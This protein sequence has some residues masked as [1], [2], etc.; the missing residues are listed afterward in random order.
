MRLKEKVAI[1]TGAGS[2][3]GK[4]I[5]LR[6]ASEGAKVCIADLK[7]D[8]AQTTVDEIRRNGGEGLAVAMNVINEQQVDAG[9]AATVEKFGG[10]DILVSNAGIQHIDA[11][12]DLS[13]DN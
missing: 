13:F 7:L 11:L 1:V 3:I 6:Y 8:S 9:V 12:I 2:G 10:V 5:A 4:E